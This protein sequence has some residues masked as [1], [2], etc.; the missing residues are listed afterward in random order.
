MQFISKCFSAV[1]SISH[2]FLSSCV[3]NCYFYCIVFKITESVSRRLTNPPGIQ[4]AF[5]ILSKHLTFIFLTLTLIEKYVGKKSLASVFFFVVLKIPS[6]L[7][8]TRFKTL[9]KMLLIIHCR[10]IRNSINAL[11]MP[12]SVVEFDTRK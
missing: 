7:N 6:Q 5:G 9:Y 2:C 12:Q 10:N 3:V 4:A 11:R 8:N 1:I